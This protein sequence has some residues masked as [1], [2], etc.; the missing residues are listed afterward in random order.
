MRTRVPLYKQLQGVPVTSATLSSLLRDYKRPLDKIAQ[1]VRDGFLIKLRRDLY[2]CVPMDSDDR[3]YS[4]GLIANHLVPHSYVSFE[5]VLSQEGIIP[6]RSYLIKSASLS[7]PI[8]YSN[9]T[10]NYQFIPVPAPYFPI[11]V[12]PKKTD[13]GLYYL[14]ASPEKALCDL[15]VTTPNLRIQSLKAMHSYLENFLR[16][17][18]DSINSLDPSIIQEC[19]LHT[20]KKS[21]ELQLLKKLVSSLSSTH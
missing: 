9:P 6:E 19:S 13:Q 5:T 3:P 4:Q 12:S 14:A 11:G 15:I 10:G 18:T 2:L 1:L 21:N 16:I 7:R 8:S 20:I 17:D